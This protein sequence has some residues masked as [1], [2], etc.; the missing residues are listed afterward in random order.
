MV[1]VIMPVYNGA[2]TLEGSVDSVLVQ[3]FRNF[4][5]I[6]CNDGSTDQTR[7]ILETITDERVR[8]VH[9][10][11]NLGEGPARDRAI[12]MAKGVWLAFIDADDAWIP[13]RLETLL[14]YAGASAE[15]IMFDDILECHDTPSGMV[16][17]QVLRGKYAFDGNGIEPVYVPIEKFLTAERFL[18]KPL[19]P[20]KYVNQYHVN[21][22]CR[23]YGED[24]EFF[25]EL[26]ARG[27]QLCYIPKPMYYYRITPG[28]MSSIAN[29][30]TMM[31]EV[32]EN[33]I[34]KFEYAPSV[35]VALYKKIKSVVRT[36]RYRPF[37]IELKKKNFSRA[38]LLAY[39]SP[40]IIFEFFHRLFKSLSYHLN[41]ILRG[42]R[43]RGIR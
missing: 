23:R 20:L 39:Q 15:K 36:E 37:V 38:L 21:H 5:L 32:L 35:Q 2:L 14:H 24:I 40:W 1:S 28:S 11:S 10:V 27:L 33:A 26:F 16:P 4:E 30:S 9:H 13:E 19:I 25:I 18:I 22:S 34:N 7:K 43:T 41:R 31:R 17:W 3:T 29:R 42:G 8:V 12:M 6:V